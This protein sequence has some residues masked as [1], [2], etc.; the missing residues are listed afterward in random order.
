M[1]KIFKLLFLIVLGVS[2]LLFLFTSHVNLK[3][4]PTEAIVICVKSITCPNSRL[5]ELSNSFIYL[6]NPDESYIFSDEY[7]INSKYGYFS[8]L[9]L[10]CIFLYITL[11]KR[12][13]L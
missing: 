1:R 9:I 5:T 6:A 12:N 13:K 2:S 7:K 10:I 8:I 11:I 3:N 4:E